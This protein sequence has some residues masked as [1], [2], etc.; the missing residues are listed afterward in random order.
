MT[1]DR[2]EE[3][4]DEIDGVRWRVDLDFLSSR[5]RCIWGEGCQGILAE[6]AEELQQGCCS[7]GAELLD[8]DESRLIAALAAT[9][10]EERFQYADHARRHGIFRDGARRHT[11]LVDGA[12]IFLNRPGF[13]GGPGCALHLQALA[14]GERPV[15]V[16]PSVCWQLPLKVDVDADGT[17]TLR[18]WEREDWGAGAE[19]AWWCTDAP[20][21][22]VGSV[23]AAEELADALG[24]LVGPEVAVAVRR[25]AAAR[26]GG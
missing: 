7:V 5:W 1:G 21:A 24:A 9:L 18:R 23:P 8:E 16:K 12:C 22:R 13:S 4:V 25:R 26:R 2:F 20:E 6:P 14:D 11:T 3:F 17:R 10:D 15:D 19:L